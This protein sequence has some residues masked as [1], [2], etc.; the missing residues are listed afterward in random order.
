[1]GWFLPTVPFSPGERKPIDEGLELR[2][3]QLQV[4]PIVVVELQIF[5]FP[6]PAQEVLAGVKVLYLF[7]PSSPNLR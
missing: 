5:K 3:E 6:A 4:E 2:L 1:M 7:S